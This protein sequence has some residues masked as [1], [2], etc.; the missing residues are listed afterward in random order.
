M[1]KYFEV[2]CILFSSCFLDNVMKC[3]DLATKKTKKVHILWHFFCLMSLEKIWL[4][5]STKTFSFVFSQWNICLTCFSWK[6][7][8]LVCI[9]MER[10]FSDWFVIMDSCIVIAVTAIKNVQITEISSIRLQVI[11]S[12]FK[13]LS[14]STKTPIRATAFSACY[15]LFLAQ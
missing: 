14:N 6:L 10:F 12:K 2:S 15:D 8:F 13:H 7:I 1:V 9:V 4:S 3:V 5:L 11:K